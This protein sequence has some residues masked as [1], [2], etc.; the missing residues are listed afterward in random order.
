MKY[1]IEY[2]KKIKYGYIGMN[3][4]ASKPHNVPWKHNEHT[5][6]IQKG[7]SKPV[8]LATE[9]HEMMEQYL[10]K[11]KHYGYHKAHNLALKFEDKSKPFPSKDIKR[12]LREMGAKTR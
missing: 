7:L 3:K 11:N 6:E 12:K 2:K 8:R 4:F 9:H 5:I 10:M 1:K